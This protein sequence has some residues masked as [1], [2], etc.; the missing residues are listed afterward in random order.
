MEIWIEQQT[1]SVRESEQSH[2][3]PCGSLH[4]PCYV[5]LWFRMCLCAKA[6]VKPVLKSFQKP[7]SCYSFIDKDTEDHVTSRQL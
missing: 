3:D 5:W 4:S 6:K 1:A 2:S 7:K